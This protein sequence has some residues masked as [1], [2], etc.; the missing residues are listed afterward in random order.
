LILFVREEA[1]GSVVVHVACTTPQRILDTRVM[2]CV[3]A[4]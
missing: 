4:S 2:C 1:E 3:V